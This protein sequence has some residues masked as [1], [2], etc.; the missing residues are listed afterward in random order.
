M[1]LQMRGLTNGVVN[2]HRQIASILERIGSSGVESGTFSNVTPQAISQNRKKITPE[3]YQ[4]LSRH[5]V[6][7][8]YGDDDIVLWRK[9]WR[10]LAVDGTTIQLPN[11][12]ECII[13]FGIT[14]P[15]TYP[16]GRLS[17][18]YDIGNRC[19]L[20]TIVSTIEDDERSMAMRHLEIL[21]LDR[22]DRSWRNLVL[23]DMNYPC[24]YLMQDILLG[25]G[26]FL[27]RYAAKGACCIAEV[28]DAL[29]QGCTDTVLE[30]DLRKPGRFINPRLKPIL[31]RMQQQGQS[32]TLCVRMVA[33][34]LPNGTR[35]VLLTSL[36]DPSITSDDFR[37]LYNERW[38]IETY[39]DVLKNVLV[40][41]KFSSPSLQGIM[42]DIYAAELLANFLA[43]ALFDAREELQAYNQAAERKYQ[44][45]INTTQALS[46][47][48]QRIV[49]MVVFQRTDEAERIV[50]ALRQGLLRNLV[51]KRPNR[52]TTT[53]LRKKKH[54]LKKHS[55]NHKRVG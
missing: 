41:E 11:S 1:L 25:G 52:P 8:F 16:L 39:Y 26:D 6:K 40:V 34:T 49:E 4:V 45:I 42:Q 44:Y 31:D 10:L 2:E 46:L 29:E 54:R 48:R 27:F 47:L 18:L 13:A 53:T 22:A 12:P 24:F 38:G 51:P 36:L 43:L 5:L 19:V 55:H 15:S 28:T 50:R 35:E 9:Q 17:V 37:E 3:A 7:S 23:A 21:E 14:A 30:I 32:T 20:D 33:L